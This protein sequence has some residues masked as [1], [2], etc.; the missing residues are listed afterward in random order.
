MEWSIL[1]VLLIINGALGGQQLLNKIARA[2]A[3]RASGGNGSSKDQAH[4]PTSGMPEFTTAVVLAWWRELFKLAWSVAAVAIEA[5]KGRPWIEFWPGWAALLTVSICSFTGIIENF[6]FYII[7]RYS[8]HLWIPYISVYLL[9]LPIF[10]GLMFGSTVR[11]EHW[12]GTL[13]VMAGLAA[14]SIRPDSLP[15][16]THAIL[17][18]EGAGHAHFATLQ[19]LD[20]QAYI[21]LLII[22]LCLCSQQ[23]LNNKSVQLATHKVSANAFVV[24]REIFKFGFASLFLGAI[25]LFTSNGVSHYMKLNTAVVFALGAGLTGYIYSWGFF[26]LSKYPVHIWVPYTNLYVIAMPFLS[27]WLLPG[28]TVTLGQLLGTLFVGAGLFVGLSDY[29]HHKIER[30]TDKQ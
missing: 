26:V 16:L 10:T 6:G 4:M 11:K 18:S 25:A 3:D 17:K 30:I 21:W 9:L 19:R 23:V 7:S 14:A 2:S 27:V 29:K 1:I 22:N 28:V 12:I 13:L 8:P 15:Q 20:L 5:I 24:W